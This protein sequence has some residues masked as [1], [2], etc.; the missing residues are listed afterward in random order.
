MRDFSR[1]T[2][3]ALGLLA[4]GSATALG[5]DG[6]FTGVDSVQVFVSGLGADAPTELTAAAVHTHIAAILTGAGI[7]IDS[8]STSSAPALRLGF[9]L[10]RLEGGWVIGVRAEVVEPSVSLRE[11]VWETARRRADP[12]RGTAEPDS[13]LGVVMRNFTTWSRFA[14]ATCPTD[15]G[16]DTA[17]AVAGQLVVE[18]TNLMQRDNAA[19]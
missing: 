7:G 14:V 2:G 5:Q 11:Y 3:L 16:Y 18:L 1:I 17:L 13:V 15:A 10:R 9:S 12:S 4:G 19:G 6:Q 8:A